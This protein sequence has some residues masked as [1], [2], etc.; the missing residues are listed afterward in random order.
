VCGVRRMALAG[1]CCAPCDPAPRAPLVC[2]ESLWGTRVN[3]QLCVSS[4]EPDLKT[5]R[6][7]HGSDN[8]YCRSHPGSHPRGRQSL[9]VSVRAHPLKGVEPELFAPEDLLEARGAGVGA[10]G[11]SGARSGAN[12]PRDAPEPHAATAAAAT[13]GGGG[14]GGSVGGSSWFSHWFG[15]N[16]RESAH[17]GAALAQPP[18]VRP[19]PVRLARV[20]P[21]ARLGP[22]LPARAPQREAACATS[23][24]LC[25]DFIF[26][27]SVW[28]WDDAGGCCPPA[29]AIEQQSLPSQPP[30]NNRPS[31]RA[32]LPCM[33]AGQ[34]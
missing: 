30:A 19:V 16:L 14:G 6:F 2:V 4:N 3:V 5:S 11:S 31:P 25:M 28:P 13:G 32:R 33:H 22:Q 1:V 10:A 17:S 7:F 18:N 34:V 24:V 21:R 12:S 15:G 8:T 20:A 29:S 23:A 27:A 9:R 26:V